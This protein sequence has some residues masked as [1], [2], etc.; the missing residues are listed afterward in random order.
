M[1]FHHTEL[2][3][4]F[5]GQ[6]KAINARLGFLEVKDTWRTI[7]LAFQFQRWNGHRRTHQG[8]SVFTNGS[9]K[10]GQVPGQT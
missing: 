6:F 8:L 10:Q 3:Q 1:S 9:G 4:A 5:G 2:A 7:T